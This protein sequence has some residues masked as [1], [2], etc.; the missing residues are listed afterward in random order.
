[1]TKK[2]GDII[3]KKLSQLNLFGK[4]VGIPGCYPELHIQKKV[5]INQCFVVK[6]IQFLMERVIVGNRAQM[7]LVQTKATY[8]G[9]PIYGHDLVIIPSKYIF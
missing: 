2:I 4:H 7:R 9:V 8:S 5:L 6:E 3:E 1:M